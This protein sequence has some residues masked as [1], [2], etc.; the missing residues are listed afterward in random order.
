MANDDI[1]PIFD[2]TRLLIGDEN[3]QKIASAHVLILG[4][5]GVGGYAVENLARAGV[6]KLTL[7]DGD[8]VDIT[9]TNRQLSALAETTGIAKTE[10]WAERIKAINPNIQ[11]DAQFR[12]LRS[13]ED[14]DSLLDNT[15]FD[16]AIDAIDEFT[17][18]IAFILA[19]KR[20]KIP[21]ISA[22]GAGG[23]LDPS[24]IKIADISKTSGCPLAR[25]VRKTLREH[26]ISKGI[27]TVYSP[28]PPLKHFADR[29]IGSIS[30]I[31]AIFGC[32]CA[33]EAVNSLIKKS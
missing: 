32:F 13:Q 1:A 22:M 18:K 21:F 31:P 33:A 20:R 2:R 9:N 19:L 15:H 7:I 10:V 4:I 24:Q 27:K 23:K 6:G 11:L 16:F 28:E 14:I 5:G 3:C 30:F 8:T 12:F 29:K 26:G 25:N 17:P